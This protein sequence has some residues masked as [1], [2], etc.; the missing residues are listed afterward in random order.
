MQK[1]YRCTRNATYSHK[2]I[3]HDDLTAR[4]GYYI[5]A[6]SEEEALQKMA[7]RFPEEMSYGFTVQEWQGFNVTVEE[8]C[9][10]EQN[11]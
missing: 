4:Q 11:E 10:P 3:G 7:V 8:I 1:E 9:H 6:S 2:C 5:K